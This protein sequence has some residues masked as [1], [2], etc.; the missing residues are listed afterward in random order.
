MTICFFGTY[1][2]VYNRNVVLLKGLRKNGVKV[3]ECRT[4]K[5]GIG[6][7]V[8]LFK[9]HLKI[10]KDYDLMVVAFGGWYVLPLARIL[11][12]KKI[13]F[14]AFFSIYDSKVFDK[15]TV[16]K[17]RLKAGFYY[18]VDWLDCRLADI[19][20]LDTNQHLNFYIKTFNVNKNKLLKVLVGADEDVFYPAENKDNRKFEVV[21]YGTLIPL[22]GVEYIVEAAKLLENEEDI[23]I[24]LIGYKDRPYA[25]NIKKRIEDLKL[26]N[27]KLLGRLSENDVAKEIR[28]ADLCLGIFGDNEKANRVIPNKIYHSIASKVPVVSGKTEAIRELFTDNKNILLCNRADSEDLT[29]KIKYLKNNKDIGKEVANNAYDLY[30]EKCRPEN[31]VKKMLNEI[32]ENF[33]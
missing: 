20:L 6:R 30:M 26:S 7:Y 19:I 27:L 12:R 4:D 13:I 16:Q 28:N 10:R 33:K 24:K 15:Q 3:I 25:N 21:F 29:E 9:K 14:D 17:G 23:N 5:T 32:N 2:P 22:Q 11:T 31:I 8:D 1:S 18:L